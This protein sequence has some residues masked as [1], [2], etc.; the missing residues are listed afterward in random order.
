MLKFR[1][2]V[3]A[4]PPEGDDAR[5]VR[6]VEA[7]GSRFPDRVEVEILPADGPEAADVGI[8]MT[9]AVFEGGM[10]ISVGPS[11]SAGRLKRYIE[12]QLGEA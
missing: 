1:I 2:F 5:V 8:Q 7:A 10:A 6:A 4:V 3:A 12:M 11:L 9:P